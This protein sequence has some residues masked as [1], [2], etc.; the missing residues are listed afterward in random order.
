MMIISDYGEVMASAGDRTTHFR[1][2]TEKGS[3]NI[4]YV[5]QV[6]ETMY[7]LVRLYCREIRSARLTTPVVPTTL[8]LLLLL[9]E[10]IE[11]D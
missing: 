8:L 11:A 9:L 6:A 5:L 2:S 7:N 3:S 4:R 1:D 10:Y